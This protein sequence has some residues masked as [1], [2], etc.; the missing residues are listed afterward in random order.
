M[1]DIIYCEENLD[2]SKK[3][4]YR[5]AVRAIIFKE[6]KILMLFSLINGD[7]KFPGGGIEKGESHSEALIRETLEEA[8]YNIV[9]NKEFIQIS[10]YDQGQ[11]EGFDIFHMLSIYYFA[12]I[13]EENK[14]E[15]VEDE[16]SLP[17]WVEAREAY[18]KN[19]ELFNKGNKAKWLKREIH[20]LDKLQ[21]YK[22]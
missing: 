1:K 15:K 2:L 3:T 9:P 18:L 6:N 4:H 7:Y 20:I 10:E 19:L 12:N 22:N 8:G 14:L 17:V 16:N 5:E 11:I 13:I 21:N